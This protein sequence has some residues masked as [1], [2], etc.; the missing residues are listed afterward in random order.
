MNANEVIANRAIQIMGGEVGTR[1]PVH[2]NDHVNMGQSSND[3][4]PTAVHVATLV[5]IEQQ[6][7]PALQVLQQGLE[8]KAAEFDDVFKAGRTHLQDATPIRLGQEFGGYASQV[9]HGISRLQK[10][11]D[12][13]GELA[14]G[15]T[16]VGTGC[17]VPRGRQSLRGAVGSRRGRGNQRGA[18]DHRL[19]PDEDRQRHQVAGLRPPDRPR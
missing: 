19:Q 17:A 8:S 7:L 16:A 1:D 12:S 14:I 2:P 15:G 3:V 13:L 9:A 11:R 5:A 18:Q 4:I 6:L 10:L